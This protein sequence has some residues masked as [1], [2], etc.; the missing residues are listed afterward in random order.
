MEVRRTG[1]VLLRALGIGLAIDPMTRRAVLLV[2]LLAALAQGRLT[3]CLH[4]IE[5][6]HEL[7][8]CTLG[9]GAHLG[10]RKV[11]LDQ[12]PDLCHGVLGHESAGSG[13]QFSARRAASAKTSICSASSF[14]FTT[15]PPATAPP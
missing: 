14:S 5:E 4:E 15:C 13:L 2:E 3:W 12:A 11:R 1:A 8:G 10:F 9:S 6:R 7:N